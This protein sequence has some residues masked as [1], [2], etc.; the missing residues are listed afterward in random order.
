MN[1]DKK[2]SEGH[3]FWQT[4]RNFILAAESGLVHTFTLG[5]LVDDFY[6]Q[7]RRIYDVMNVMEAIGC[8]Q[9]MCADVYV[10]QGC[11]NV[12]T[13][14]KEAQ[15]KNQINS[16]EKSVMECIPIESC[17]SMGHLSVSLLLCFMALNT[18][19]L[20]IKQVAL[21]LAR[22]NKRYKTMLC[23]LYQISH[24]LEAIG[25]FTKSDKMGELTLDKQFFTVLPLEEQKPAPKNIYS[26]DYFLNSPQDD[27]EQVYRKRRINFL[28]ACQQTD[29]EFTSHFKN[30]YQVRGNHSPVLVYANA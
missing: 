29:V 9:K 19:N 25:I 21:F 13:V 24:I 20:N 2:K 8:S 30:A 22:E 27:T 17:I 4:I 1:Q 14:L 16:K 26:I 23:K 3:E 10:W 15:I 18:Q 11:S 6:I 7:R 12:I 5:N 28:C